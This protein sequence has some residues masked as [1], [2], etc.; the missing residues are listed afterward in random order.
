MRLLRNAVV[1]SLFVSLTSSLAPLTLL[2]ADGPSQ[3]VV[4][5]S[6]HRKSVQDEVV[7][8]FRDHYRKTF[9]V[10]V[11]VEWLD[12]GGTSDD[13]RFVRSKF[14]QNPKTAEIDVFWGG[15]AT[16]FLDMKDQGLLA[17]YDLPADLK[18]AIPETAA[19]IPLY[20]KSHTWYA[21]ALS[22]FGIFSN[23]AVAKL[24]K[25]DPP[26]TWT[27]LG[28]GRF[29][30][31][32]VLTDP[33]RS[34]TASV[35]DQVILQALGWER[36]WAELTK[37]HANVKSFVHSSSDPIK[38]VVAGDSLTSMSIDYYA[39]PKLLDLGPQALDFV[40]PHEQT[41]LD[42]DPIAILK[43]APNRVVAERFVNY[44]LS[45]E[46]Q[47]ML[48][49]PTKSDGGPKTSTLGRMAVR[50]DAYEATE[51]RRLTAFNPLTSKPLLKFNYDAASK[52]RAPL[53][54]LIGAVH[55][56]LHKEL[57]AAWKAILDRGATSEDVARLTK[58]LASEQELIALS[59]TWTQ[60]LKRN[61]K[62]NEWSARARQTYLDLSSAQP[63][64]AATH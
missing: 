16:A 29:Y 4:V 30:R 62:I 51:G 22:S 39:V 56:D 57:Q 33:R 45:L 18:A 47:K 23:L 44:V 21:S 54:D 58:P 41:I 9:G 24:E 40:L 50:Q 17:S 37:I 59:A 3:R 35:M 48:M 49:L 26:K 52:Y 28:E 5:I 2:G 10:E 19:G 43:G 27:D 1:P 53:N 46:A 42:A 64:P 13:I 8:L 61:A 12:Q 36:G 31:K 55:V 11:E 32:V 38:A 15:G 60:D 6:P 25:V 7:P 63:K 14:A 34:G 20:D